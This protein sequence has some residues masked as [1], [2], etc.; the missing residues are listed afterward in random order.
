MMWFLDGATCHGTGHAER[1]SR[2]CMRIFSKVH[3]SLRCVQSASAPCLKLLRTRNQEMTYHSSAG[4]GSMRI[5]V[6]LGL[7]VF[8]IAQ[9]GAQLQRTPFFY[10]SAA[11]R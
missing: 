5:A 4:I 3:R 11:E 1:R 6:S 7:I 8:V 10:H 9:E 2:G